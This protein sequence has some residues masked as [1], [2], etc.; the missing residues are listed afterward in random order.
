MKIFF[1]EE[2]KPIKLKLVR[3]IKQNLICAV[4]DIKT[5]NE[6]E[7]LKNLTLFVKEKTYHYLMMM[8]FTKEIC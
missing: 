5:R 8:S 3:K 1:R 2:T 6:A 4:E 7:K